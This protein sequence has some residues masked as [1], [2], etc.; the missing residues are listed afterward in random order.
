M[1]PNIVKFYLISAIPILLAL[2]L[3]EYAHAFVANRLGDSTAKSMGRLTLNPLAHLDILGTAMLFIVQIGW[4]KPVPVNPALLKNPHRD[5]LWISL[6]GP[7][8]NLSLALLF[9]IACR[10]AGVDGLYYYDLDAA[11]LVKYMLAYGLVINIVLAVFNFLPIPPLDGSKIIM[12]LFPQKYEL[13]L[14]PYLHYGPTILIVLIVFGFVTRIP[15][16]QL[17]LNPFVKFFSYIFTGA[18]FHL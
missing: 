10:I 3:H 6:A 17:I 12:G 2:T 5:M 11:G 7:M 4:A 18:A 8:M 13:K 9:G 16:I 1:D 14:S 15:V